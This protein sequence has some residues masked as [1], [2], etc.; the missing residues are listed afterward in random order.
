MFTSGYGIY[1]LHNWQWM[2]YSYMIGS[3]IKSR[4]TSMIALLEHLNKFDSLCDVCLV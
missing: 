3:A 2:R 4:V 1:L